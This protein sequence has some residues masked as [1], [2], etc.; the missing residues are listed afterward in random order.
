M[1]LTV[2]Q[3]NDKIMMDTTFKYVYIVG[4]VCYL[5]DMTTS[6]LVYITGMIATALLKLTARQ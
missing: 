5:A 6:D 3:E 1:E 2:P 4:D